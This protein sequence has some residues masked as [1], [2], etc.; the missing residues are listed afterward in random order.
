L[1]F[2][3]IPLEADTWFSLPCWSSCRCS[4]WIQ[5]SWINFTTTKQL[6]RQSHCCQ[7]YSLSLVKCSITVESVESFSTSAYEGKHH[8]RYLSAFNKACVLSHTAYEIL[9]RLL[10]EWL[11]LES[12]G[13][14]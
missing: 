12:Q 11:T 5:P 7:L 3:E 14:L 6:V 8:Q 2:Q 1:K 4:S 13:P 10:G 9:N